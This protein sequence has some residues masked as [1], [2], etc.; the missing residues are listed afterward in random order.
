MR[1]GAGGEVLGH[2]VGRE[3][4]HGDEQQQAQVGE[5]GEPV[6]LPHAREHA[7]VV[8]PND[9]DDEKAHQIGEVGR[10]LIGE[11]SAQLP[12]RRHVSPRHGEVEHEQRDRNGE[13]AVAEGFEAAGTH[14]HH[15]N[16]HGAVAVTRWRQISSAAP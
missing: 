15:G 5:E 1:V 10:P 14:R 4:Q 7:V 11:L 9:P 8:D 12:G 16:D 6:D 2:E 13:D 3:G